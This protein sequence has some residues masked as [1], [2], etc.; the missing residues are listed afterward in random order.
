MGVV[1]GHD[2]GVVVSSGTGVRITEAVR[3]RTASSVGVAVGVGVARHGAGTVWM[4]D[5]ES[6]IEQSLSMC[7][8]TSSKGPKIRSWLYVPT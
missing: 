2:A 1:A 8:N 3:N 5:S 6:L 7:T 4:L